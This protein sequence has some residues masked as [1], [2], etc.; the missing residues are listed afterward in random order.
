MNAYKI[1]HNK[2]VTYYIG[3]LN[4]IL[5]G[6]CSLCY[7]KK[8]NKKLSFNFMKKNILAKV[9]KKLFGGKILFGYLDNRPQF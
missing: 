8:L 1:S 9:K 6:F 4:I 5:K 2:I 7:K 3:E